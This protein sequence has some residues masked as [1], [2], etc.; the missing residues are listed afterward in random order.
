MKQMLPLA[1][2]SVLLLT[3][4]GSA[5]QNIA[6]EPQALCSA[7]FALKAETVSF[8]GPGGKTL[9][10]KLYKPNGKGPFPAVIWNHGSGLMIDP[11]RHIHHDLANLYAGK[12][13]V[14]FTPH[15]T[16]HGLSKDAGKSAVEGEANCAGPD[17][18]EMRKCRVKYHEE[19]NLDTVAAV[20]WLQ[21]QRY[22][23]K[24]Q[25]MMSGV[26]Y[27]AIQTILTADKDLGIQA[28]VPFSPAAMSWANLQLRQRLQEALE[29]ARAPIFLIQADGDFSTGP[30][31]LLGGYLKSKGGLNQAKLY[32]KFG[33]TP[34]EAHLRFAITCPGI[35]IW[36][37]DVLNFLKVTRK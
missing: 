17:I 19:A 22:V 13:Y 11:A 18:Q 4:I 9:F 28:F 27:G 1:I 24:N 2:L 3:N 16:G 15:R 10:G 7:K 36:G 8:P 14:F 20:K 31:E 32:P 6:S 21:A 37:K 35:E 34:Q 5:Q 30:Y 29:K 26:S 23:K 12:D 25:I 33:T